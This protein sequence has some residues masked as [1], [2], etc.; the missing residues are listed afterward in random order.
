MAGVSVK[1]RSSLFI[2]KFKNL[3]QRKPE[4]ALFITGEK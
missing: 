3:Q 2:K 4:S 1:V